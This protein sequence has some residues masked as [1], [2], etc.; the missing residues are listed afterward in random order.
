ME[1][2]RYKTLFQFYYGSINSFL[3]DT[4]A[5]VFTHFNSTMVQLIDKGEVDTL[6]NGI[7]FNST[8][9]QLIGNTH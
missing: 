5:S 1:L 3:P 2:C 8:M 7:Y 4:V 6:N 9:V